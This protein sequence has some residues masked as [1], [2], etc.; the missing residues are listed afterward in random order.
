MTYTLS[1]EQYD[2]LS[3]LAYWIADEMYLRE[4]YGNDEPEI[5]KAQ[6]TI[7]FLF[8]VLDKAK[9]PFWVQNTVIAFSENWRRYKT[10]YLR[11]Y[12]ETKNVFLKEKLVCN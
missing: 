8:D 7:S 5:K 11:D 6:D 10:E 4:R 2:D 9:V 3:S 1:Q 12:L